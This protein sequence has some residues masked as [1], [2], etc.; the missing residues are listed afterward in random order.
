MKKYFVKF[1]YSIITILCN[2]DEEAEKIARAIYRGKSL[3]RM[4]Q[5][6][7]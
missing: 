3:M 4:S 7:L 1:G 5:P 2:S 6:K